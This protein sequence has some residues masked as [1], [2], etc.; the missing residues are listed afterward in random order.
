M[1]IPWSVLVSVVA[2]GTAEPPV[3]ADPK[4]LFPVAVG[5]RWEFVVS[6]AGSPD[7]LKVQSITGTAGSGFNFETQRG[8]A[9]TVSVQRLDGTK[10]VRVSEVSYDGPTVVE[11][12]T[13]TPPALR[14]ETANPKLGDTYETDHTE[15]HVDEDGNVIGLG[16]RKL[17]SFIVEA[18]DEAITVPAGTF[19]CVRLRR[20]TVGGASKTFWYAPGIGKIREVGGQTESLK[21]HSL[22]DPG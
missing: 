10:L 9:K 3:P 11:R 13:F 5:N 6:E 7:S 4:S 21:S 20:T 19:V 12:L 1:K 15:N 16:A 8:A 17:E 18:I 22:V 2:C 14:V